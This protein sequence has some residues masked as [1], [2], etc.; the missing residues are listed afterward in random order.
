MSTERAFDTNAF[1]DC[2]IELTIVVI[3]TVDV[4][5]HGSRCRMH[6]DDDGA[7]WSDG[8]INMIIV[9]VLNISI[10]VDTYREIE[11]EMQI[12]R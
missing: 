5:M 8:D 7:G 6:D 4:I 1:G 9:F 10:H 12:E 2:C 11:G 3:L